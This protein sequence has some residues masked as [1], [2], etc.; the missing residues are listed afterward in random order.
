MPGSWGQH[1]RRSA[2]CPSYRSTAGSLDPLSGDFSRLH[3]SEVS[4]PYSSRNRRQEG[5]KSRQKRPLPLPAA[6]QV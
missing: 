1:A 3:R 6:L 4:E 5:L 2:K